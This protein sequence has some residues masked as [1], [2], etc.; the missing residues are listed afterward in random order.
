MDINETQFG[1]RKDLGTREDLFSLN[2]MIQRM[3]IMI[4]NNYIKSLLK[5]KWITD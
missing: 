3:T 5:G 1:F 2:E 4:C